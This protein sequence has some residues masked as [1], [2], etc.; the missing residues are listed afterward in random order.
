[1]KMITTSVLKELS[2]A[3]SIREATIFP[4]ENGYIFIVKIGMMERT[5]RTQRNNQPRIFKT[6][7]PAL[8]FARSIGLSQVMVELADWNM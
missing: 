6:I 7:E 1:M 3:K 2:E 8:R 4:N 5:L